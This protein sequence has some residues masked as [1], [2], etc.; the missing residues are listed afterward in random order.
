MLVYTQQ[1]IILVTCPAKTHLF[2]YK[3]NSKISFNEYNKFTI[4]IIVIK[5]VSPV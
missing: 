4:N 1:N 5:I 3:L 2:I